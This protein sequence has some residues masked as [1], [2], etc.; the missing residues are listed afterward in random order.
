MKIEINSEFFGAGVNSV[1][2]TNYIIHNIFPFL[3][4]QMVF[5]LVVY[6]A[7]NI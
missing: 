3:Q 4:I 1:T 2:K 6:F 5:S 7:F